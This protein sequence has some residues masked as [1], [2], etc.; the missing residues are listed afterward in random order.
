MRELALKAMKG[1]IHDYL[2]K[3]ITREKA[4]KRL[5]VEVD[6]DYISNLGSDA[7]DFIITDCFY[8]IKHLAE[9]GYETTDEEIRYFDE[10]LNGERVYDLNEKNHI[11]LD[12]FE[13]AK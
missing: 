6:V 12:H 11:L 13:S 5:I 7:D 9:I 4:V 1:I 10:Y 8:A 2:N 3:S